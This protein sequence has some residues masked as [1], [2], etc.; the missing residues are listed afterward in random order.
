MS[1]FDQSYDRLG[2]VL[3]VIEDLRVH[4]VSPHMHRELASSDEEHESLLLLFLFGLIILILIVLRVLPNLIL[5]SEVFKV[6]A[7]EDTLKFDD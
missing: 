4:V 6:R 5:L 1:S 2:L 7:R 3:V